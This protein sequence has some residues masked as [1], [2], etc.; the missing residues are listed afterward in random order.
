MPNTSAATEGTVNVCLTR[1]M[2]VKVQLM[3]V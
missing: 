1:Q 2:Q 3:Y